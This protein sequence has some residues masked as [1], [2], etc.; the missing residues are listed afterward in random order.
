MWR[1]KCSYR[2]KRGEI[3]TDGRKCEEEGGDE[4]EKGEK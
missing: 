1:E 4:K 2:K 3:T